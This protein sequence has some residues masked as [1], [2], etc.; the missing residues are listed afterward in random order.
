MKITPVDHGLQN[1]V[2]K[3]GPRS[4]GLHMSDLYGGLYKSLE[5]NRFTGAP[6][7]PLLLELGLSWE[8]MLERELKARLLGE[9]PEELITSEGIFY[10]PDLI[11]FNGSVRVGEMKLTYLSSRE[12]PRQSANSF[13]PKFDRYFTQMMASAYH[14]DTNEARLFAFFINGDYTHKGPE[15]LAWDITFSK[16]ELDDNWQMLKNYGRQAGLL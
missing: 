15:L 3:S 14:L 13:P 5:P 1:L 9:R 4:K 2:G 11:I 8:T 16:R 7:N 12:V 10:N 6:P